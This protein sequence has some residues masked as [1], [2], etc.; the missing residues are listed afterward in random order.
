M[1]FTDLWVEKVMRC[2]ESISYFM[3]LNG[4]VEDQIWPTRGLRQGDPLSP[5]SFLIC[6]KGL[7]ALLRMEALH[8][9]M[10]GIQ[11][12]RY[13]P[14]VTHLLFADDSFI[15]GEASFEGANAL[16]M[17]LDKYARSLVQVINFDKS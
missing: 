11:I 14:T 9:R 6:G 7:S 4:E 3:V 15:F 16:K 13:A 17:I 10:C 5:Y 8:G 1:G 2:V 12:N